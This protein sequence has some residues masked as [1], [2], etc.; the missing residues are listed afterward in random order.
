MSS[1]ILNNVTDVLDQSTREL[2]NTSGESSLLG[3]FAFMHWMNEFVL[4]EN[5]ERFSAL[6]A[7]HSSQNSGSSNGTIDDFIKYII[8]NASGS[9]L[10]EAVCNAAESNDITKSQCSPTPAT[11]MENKV[12]V[13]NAYCMRDIMF[14]SRPIGLRK[15]LY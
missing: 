8:S 13:C 10:L 4:V 9:E 2:F 5:L 14:S 11:P 1:A 12:E 15:T 7:S 3:F 6:L